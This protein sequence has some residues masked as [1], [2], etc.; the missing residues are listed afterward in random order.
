MP[1]WVGLLGSWALLVL[2][3]GIVGYAVAAEAIT[4]TDARKLKRV[5]T[6]DLLMEEQV[7][8]QLA[9]L[10][11]TM[12]E[13]SSKMTTLQSEVAS[14]QKQID[15]LHDSNFVITVST[16]ENKVYA[17]RNGELVFEAI[18][19]TGSNSTLTTNTGTKVFRT[20]IGRFRIQSRE[21]KPMWVPPDWHYVEEAQK[22]GLG[23]VHLQRGQNIGGLTV[24]GTEVFDNGVP[25]ENGKLI[26]RGGAVV[27]PP[28]G[29]RPRQFPD[30]L[31]THRL[32]LGD[33]YALHGTQAVSQLGRS[34]SHGCVRLH[35]DD[36]A[37]LYEMASVGDEVIIY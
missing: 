33:G 37:R 21:E 7:A 24:S 19:S 35:N 14:T 12:S 10:Q 25:V 5:R 28:V 27:I 8:K 18:C 9:I 13:A 3:L 22:N 34:V 11:N 16:T 23:I 15:D 32:N 4:M 1:R 17:R 6:I 26:V 31:G 30:V 36:I 20:P 2:G 29:T